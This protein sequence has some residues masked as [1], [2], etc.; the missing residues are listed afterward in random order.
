VKTGGA[1]RRQRHRN[2]IKK[3][4]ALASKQKGER[5]RGTRKSQEEKN[6]RAFKT[7][8]TFCKI[9]GIL[10]AGKKKGV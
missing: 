3:I 9:M 10:R 7:W 8:L 2:R 5:K 4:G 6:A 1:C